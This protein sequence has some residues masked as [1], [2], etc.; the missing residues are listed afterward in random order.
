MS[1]A[2]LYGGRG[3]YWRENRKKVIPQ[4]TGQSNT[5]LWRPD[6]VSPGDWCNVSG[7][8]RDDI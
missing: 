2:V 1:D 6:A 8:G 4:N 7:E 5:H 3:R